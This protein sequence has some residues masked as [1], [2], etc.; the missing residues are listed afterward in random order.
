MTPTTLRPLVLL[1]LLTACKGDD[2]K[3]TGPQNGGDDG[4]TTQEPD[5]DGDGVVDSEDRVPTDERVFPGAAEVCDDLDNNCDGTVDEGVTTALFFDADGDGHAGDTHV[6]EACG[7]PPGF[8]AEATDCDDLD[9]TVHPDADEVCDDVDNDCDGLTDDADDSIDPSTF[10][11][12]RDDDGY[13]N[14][15][16]TV[17]ACTVPS[18]HVDIGGDCQDDDAYVNPTNVW[19]LDYDGDGFGGSAY[20][21][22]SCEQPPGHAF[23]DWDCDDHDATVHIDAVEVCDGID[24]NCS[25]LID[26]ADSQLDTSTHTTWYADNDADGFG[27]PAT[28]TPSCAQ[29]SGHVADGTDCDDTDAAVNPTNLWHLDYDGDGYGATAYTTASCEQPSGHVADATDC[30]DLDAA[31]NPGATEVCDGGTDNDCDGLADD[32]DTTL[33]RATQTDWYADSDADGYGDADTSTAACEVPSGFVDD[34]T[35]CDDTDATVSP[36]TIWYADMDGDGYGTTAYTTETCDRPSGYVA[37][38]TDCNDIDADVNPGATEVCDGGTDNDCDG[39]ADDDDTGT[40]SGTMTTWYADADA[41][42]Y[43]DLGSTTLACTVPTGYLADA[44]DCDDTDGSVSPAGV[45]VCGDGIDNDCSE[46]APECILDGGDYLYSDGDVVITGEDDQYG[47]AMAAVDLDGDGFEELVVG[48]PYSD[49]GG[50]YAGH[51]QLYDGA[52]TSGDGDSLAD[53]RF[54]AGAAYERAGLAVA[55]AGDL[56]GDG[57]DELLIGAYGAG[58]NHHGAAYL[59]YGGTTHS[60]DVTLGSSTATVIEGSTASDGLGGSMQGVGDLD[61]DGFADLAVGARGYDCSTGSSCGAVYLFYGSASGVTG[62]SADTAAD[63]LLYGS[64]NS[65]L[66]LGPATIGAGDLD[67]DGLSDL[68]VGQPLHYPTWG[69]SHV[70]L[71]Y[72]G[73][74]ALSGTMA[75]SSADATIQGTGSFDGFGD[76]V[77]LGDLTGDGYDDLLVSE[78][79]R[80]GGYGEVFLFDGDATPL[81]GTM[82]PLSD[83]TWSVQGDGYNGQF[84]ARA[85]LG[86]VDTD[87]QLDL[88]VS[89]P[90]S[91]AEQS[92]GGEVFVFLGPITSAPD[93]ADAEMTIAGDESYGQIGGNGLLSADVNHDGADDIV[94]GEIS[95]S[96]STGQASIFFGALGM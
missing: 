6:L 93:V 46:D 2:P 4:D 13:G 20:T 69:T 33:D 47:Y 1:A 77:V 40:D 49:D 26:D 75:V 64:V 5:S 41:D 82:Y 44:S 27:D 66:G 34:A 71:H 38:D 29:P 79:N 58:A 50:T 81:S 12:D 86:D 62:G 78:V 51:V 15:S 73:S 21:T 59:V 35:D 89:E 56:D 45:E 37:D 36:E 90:W 25:G 17:L 70:F 74:S 83:A 11:A 85:V 43:G 28:S 32:A 55:N 9:P 54:L 24:N 91:H 3:A 16:R 96:D 67:G 23:T 53:A 72:G 52:D 42:G 14:D 76:N 84:G 95:G 19:F 80:T 88:I 92:Y 18:G 22:Q 30:D 8:Y 94:V 10:Y 63:A 61:G 39:L 31:V 57:T 65:R 7:A 87:G 68:V 60:G 48:A